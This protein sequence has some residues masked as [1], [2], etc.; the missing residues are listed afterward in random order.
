MHYHMQN[1]TIK[2][3]SFNVN[4]VLN[5]V[6]RNKILSKLRKEMAQIALLQETHMNQTEHAKL[7]RMGFKHIFSSSDESKHKRG[8]AILISNTQL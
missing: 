1:N 2:L 7:K 3:I 4:G 5:P 6:K 8:V